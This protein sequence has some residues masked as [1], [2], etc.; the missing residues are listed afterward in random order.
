MPSRHHLFSRSNRSQA[1]LLDT[2]EAN[3]QRYAESP[4]HSPA[5]PPQ[6]APSPHYDDEE[7]VQSYS[8]PQRSEEARFY[9]LGQP[10]RSQSQRVPSLINTNHPTIHLVAPHNSSASTPSSAVDENPDRF[11]QQGPSPPA[12]K[13]EP[14]KRRFFGLGGS[15]SSKESGKAPS[16]PTQKLGRSIS[17]RRK[18]Q[19]DPQIY[20]DS[21]QRNSQQR[22]S[23][24][25]APAEE[26]DYEDERGPGLYAQHNQQY[27]SSPQHTDK[28]PL[29]SPAFPP[30]I[31]HEEYVYGKTSQQGGAQG[32]NNRHPL[33]RQGSYQSSWE[34]AA[35]QVQ[36]HS[37]SE[38]QQTPS[39]YHPSPS[40]ATSTSSHQF[41]TRH[42][43]HQQHYHD[44]NNRPPSQQSL[45]PPPLP[46]HHP[47]I[48]DT[49]HSKSGQPQE[50][51]SSYAQGSMGPP[52]TQ[53][54]PPNRR[55]SESTQQNQN[56]SN[57][58]GGIYQPY[59]QTIQQAPVLPSNAPPPQY[60]A[61]LTPQGQNYRGSSAPSPMAQQG[62]DHG[63]STPPPSRSRDDLTEL[64]VGQLLSR[65]DEL[66][67]Y[68]LLSQFFAIG[69]CSSRMLMHT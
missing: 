23:T 20:T 55:S 9:Q 40:S 69:K 5:L 32:H 36:K 22:W 41:T 48:S 15:S 21:G 53:Q 31:S 18:E 56:S 51:A 66:R 34:R 16:A 38:S 43:T 6:S 30:P 10:T 54:Q 2:Q 58:E 65:H 17:V 61:Q 12:H 11:Y 50:S 59:S 8:L 33:E 42:E 3:N 52:P 60:S 37:R 35:Q 26:E 4:L 28:D 64:D 49:H 1:S 29:K 39:S 47:R 57:R 67:M 62:S 63:R 46:G 13:A 45:E 68:P 24:A 44:Q 27:L 19:V 14:R 25:E 7:E